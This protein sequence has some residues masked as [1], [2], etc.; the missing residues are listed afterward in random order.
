MAGACVYL[1][2]GTMAIPT[3]SFKSIG[4]QARVHVRFNA[5]NPT[6]FL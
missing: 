1:F 2:K 6:H 5:K 3:I 4:I